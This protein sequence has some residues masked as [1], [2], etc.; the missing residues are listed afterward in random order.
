MKFPIILRADS[1]L[2]ANQVY[3][4]R[5]KCFKYCVARSENAEEKSFGGYVEGGR[6]YDDYMPWKTSVRE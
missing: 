5:R 2:K 4:T 6:L 3:I 1:S